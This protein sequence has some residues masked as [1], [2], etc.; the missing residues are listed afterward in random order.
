MAANTWFKFYSNALDDRRLKRIVIKTGLPK[1]QVIGIWALLLSL[2]NRDGQLS[3]PGNIPLTAMEIIWEIGIDQ[4]LGFAV[5]D[6]MESVGLISGD[7]PFKI[8][9]WDKY[10]SPEKGSLDEFRPGVYNR[11]KSCVYCGGE[12]EHLDHITP[13]SKGGEDALNNLVAACA[14]CNQ[15]KHDSD[16]LTWYRHQPFFKATRLA[17]ILNITKAN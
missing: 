2:A 10:K 5:I 7:V 15:S 8:L 9:E 6:E 3:L 13:R 12:P 11:D 17:Y 1:Y 16:M 14:R 4:R